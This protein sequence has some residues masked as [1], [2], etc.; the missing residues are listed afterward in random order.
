MLPEARPDMASDD[1]ALVAAIR[2]AVRQPLVIDTLCRSLEEQLRQQLGG[3]SVYIGKR[4]SREQLRERDRLIAA[5]FTGD[6]YDALAKR[7]NLNARHVRRIIG[8][9]K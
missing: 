6:N 3:S 9:K 4:G 1:D 7:W 2:H 5:E 8:S